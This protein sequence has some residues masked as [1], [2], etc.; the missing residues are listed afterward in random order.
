MMDS[1]WLYEVPSLSDAVGIHTVHAW[2]Q[3]PHAPMYMLPDSFLSLCALFKHQ[4]MRLRP[5]AEEVRMK[6]EDWVLLVP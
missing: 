6:P 2:C 4:L 1:S 5:P 3:T